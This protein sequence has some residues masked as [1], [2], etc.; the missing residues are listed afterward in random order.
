M[1]S[2]QGFRFDLAYG[3]AVTAELNERRIGD[4]LDPN[5]VT[6]IGVIGSESVFQYWVTPL[7]SFS[8]KSGNAFVGFDMATAGNLTTYPSNAAAQLAGIKKKLILADAY[9]NYATGVPGVSP[10][11]IPLVGDVIPAVGGSIG[12]ANFRASRVASTTPSL[13]SIGLNF[14]YCI[15]VGVKLSLTKGVPVRIMDLRV[16]NA[17]IGIHE[18]FGDSSDEN[19]ITLNSAPV[20]GPFGMN[21]LQGYSGIGS[22]KYQIRSVPEP[23]TLLAISAGLAALARRRRK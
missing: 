23:A 7:E 1:S 8:V 19:G 20:P 22:I 16:K 13:R 6:K 11:D 2:A 14:S 4:F 17:S 18:I 5:G 9:E 3:D 10:D 21:G 12:Q 15:G